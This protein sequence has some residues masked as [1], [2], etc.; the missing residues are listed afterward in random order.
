MHPRIPVGSGPINGSPPSADTIVP[1]ALVPLSA[2]WATAAGM[3]L[4]VFSVSQVST[5]PITTQKKHIAAIPPHGQP[6]YP[7]P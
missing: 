2:P 1:M 3:Q 5:M 4:P 6:G 7:V